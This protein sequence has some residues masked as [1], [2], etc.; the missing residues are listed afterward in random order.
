MGHPKLTPAKPGKSGLRAGSPI[1]VFARVQCL[2]PKTGQEKVLLCSVTKGVKRR[3]STMYF[4]ISSIWTLDNVY[5][6]VALHRFTLGSLVVGW[7]PS[8]PPQSWISTLARQHWANLTLWLTD[9]EPI[10]S[11]YNCFQARFS[12]SLSLLLLWTGRVSV[13]WTL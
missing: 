1:A 5:T 10:F 4:Y 8:F 6:R 3:V 7:S 13:S 9:A 12:H 11:P 2:E